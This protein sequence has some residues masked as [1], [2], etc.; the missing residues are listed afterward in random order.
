M[1]VCVC[2]RGEDKGCRQR[3]LYSLQG[4]TFLC[5]TLSALIDVPLS[6]W[7]VTGAMPDVQLQNVT[8][9]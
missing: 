4:C 9:L 3:L 7:C 1:G 8:A 2:V 5:Q 6:L